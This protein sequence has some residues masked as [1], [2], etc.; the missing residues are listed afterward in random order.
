MIGNT[1]VVAVINSMGSCHSRACH[2]VGCQIWQ[3]YIENNIWLT[4]AHISGAKN[5]L[6]DIESRHFQSQDKE[7]KLNPLSLH[8]AL[9]TLKFQPE[10]D[11]FASR[12]NKQFSLYCSYKP[13]PKAMFVDAFSIS[14]ADSK[15]YCFSPC[16]CLLNNSGA[17]PGNFSCPRLAHPALVSTV[18]PAS[19]S[20]SS[21]S[22]T[23]SHTAEP[24]SLSGNNSTPLQKAETFSMSCLRRQ[25]QQRGYSLRSIEII[26]SSWRDSTKS[27]YQVHL[28]K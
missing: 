19:C 26:E 4:D 21:G 20:T 3:F 17:C 27:Q 5:V 15:F 7:W 12:L 1:T 18:G 9:N 23:Q 25:L 24:L 22:G 2:S 10:I 28:Q 8:D 14:W 13:D 16:S 11:L 6:A